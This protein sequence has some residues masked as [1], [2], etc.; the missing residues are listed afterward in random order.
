MLKNPIFNMS[1]VEEFYD[2]YE[3]ARSAVKTLIKDGLVLKIRA[4]LYTCVSGE[5]GEPVA[6]RFQIASRL[7]SS[8]YIS[9][10]TAME[11]YGITDQV[12]YD[13]Y[14]SSESSFREFEFGGYT[15]HYIKSKIQDGVDSPL[16]SGGIKVTNIERTIIDSIKDMDKI[17]GMEEV[18]ENINSVSTIK[19]EFLLKYLAQYKNQFL[20]QKVGFLMQLDKN[21]FN[22]SDD[23]YYI[24]QKNMGKSTR[25]L[26]NEMVNFRYDKKWKLMIPTKFENMKNGA[27]VDA[28]I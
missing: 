4:N 22:L 2:S 5:T 20:Y 15:Y 19:E 23:F 8:A 12:F 11:Y 24:C 25:Y 9:H 17:S 16:Y 28:D 26:T 7:T 10:H 6:N 1:D 21:R 14:V 3:G 27:I 18:V 13:V